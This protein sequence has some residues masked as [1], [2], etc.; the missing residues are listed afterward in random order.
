MRYRSQR[1]QRQGGDHEHFAM[2]TDIASSCELGSTCCELATAECVKGMRNP[3]I[4]A[5]LTAHNHTKPQPQIF[6]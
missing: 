3:R 6:A 4:S 1:T 5:S 2:R